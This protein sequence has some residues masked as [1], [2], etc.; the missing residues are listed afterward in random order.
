M[1]DLPASFDW[2]DH[3]VVTAVK[4]QGMCGSCW[5]FAAT[6]ALESAA[7]IA[8][9]S[10]PVIL[11]PQQ[12]V[13]CTPNPDKCGGTG[14]CE[15]ATFELAYDYLAGMDGQALESEYRYHQKDMQCKD[16]SAT[17]KAAVSMTGYTN[18]DSNNQTAV[19]DALVNGGPLGIVVDAGG[20]GMYWSGV[21]DSCSYS[22]NIDLDHGV[23]LVGY[24][25]ENGK[26]F[27]I[28]RNS[29]GGSWGREGYIYL[30]RDDTA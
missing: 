2:R 22:E 9:N 8:S 12:L 29:W 4:N 13:D 10:D 19:M 26:K 7:A 15:G 17:F 5:A 3:N 25:E 20:W 14:G 16:S 21:F 28:V 27:W 30:A 24:G 18:V 6:E 1:K 23:L 11:A